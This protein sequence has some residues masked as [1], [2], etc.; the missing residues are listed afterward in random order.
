MWHVASGLSSRLHDST[1]DRARNEWEPYATLWRLH[2]P[3]DFLVLKNGT[4]PLSNPAQRMISQSSTVD[5]MRFWLEHEADSDPQKLE[6]YRR[7]S[8]LR[9]IENRGSRASALTLN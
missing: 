4:H 5:W 2:K 8:R 9:D 1:I 3:V 6:Q 7:W